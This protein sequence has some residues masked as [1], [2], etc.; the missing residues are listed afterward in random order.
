M[1]SSPSPTW[2]LEGFEHRDASTCKIA[3]SSLV[4]AAFASCFGQRGPT[5][6]QHK[7]PKPSL[8]AVRSYP[9]T[10]GITHGCPGGLQKSGFVAL[11]LLLG[12]NLCGEEEEVE[13]QWKK[14]PACF[15]VLLM[16]GTVPLSSLMPRILLTQQD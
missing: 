13:L 3:P 8:L 11:L 6:A 16:E 14:Y 12:M 2:S 5:C 9:L 15:K 4:K 7:H 1:G 10:G